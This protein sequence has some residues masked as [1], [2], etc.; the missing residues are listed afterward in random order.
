MYLHYS[1]LT[2]GTQVF[3]KKKKENQHTTYKY[4]RYEK[5]FLNFV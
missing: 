5:Y 3:K 1:S 2:T 4:E